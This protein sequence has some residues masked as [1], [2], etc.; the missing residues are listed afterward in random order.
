M[1]N[2]CKLFPTG[3]GLLIGA[4]TAVVATSLAV[5]SF[6]SQ[7]RAQSTKPA[8]L[9]VLSRLDIKSELAERGFEN[10]SPS[11]LSASEDHLLIVAAA[12]IN[13]L[14]GV[15]VGSDMEGN[16]GWTTPVKETVLD[17]TV[18][19]QGAVAALVEEGSDLTIT[20]RQFDEKGKN[21]GDGRA[22]PDVFRLLFAGSKL[23][24]LTRTGFL[25]ELT[26]SRGGGRQVFP[27]GIV[28]PSGDTYVHALPAGRM[29]VIDGKNATWSESSARS[30]GRAASLPTPIRNRGVEKAKALY[31]R[32]GT[33]NGIIVQ[34]AAGEKSGPSYLLLTGFTPEEGAPVIVMDSSGAVTEELRL[35]V[36]YGGASDVMPFPV[37][38]AVSGNKLAMLDS[39]GVITIFRLP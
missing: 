4:L 37:S 30:P 31:T 28:L 35:D 34:A 20:L 18:N 14:N 11:R 6:Q 16:I 19:E 27:S 38:L 12:S 10:Q 7:L 22:Y 8:F 23:Y 21:F 39:L 25:R 1:Q 5:F 26:D 32:R 15:L 17:A 24:G 9:E 33:A 2:V 29:R 36:V 13:G 3:F